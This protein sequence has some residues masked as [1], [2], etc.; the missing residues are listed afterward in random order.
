MANPAPVPPAADSE[1][2]FRGCMSRADNYPESLTS[3]GPNTGSLHAHKLRLDEKAPDV[4][5]HRSTVHVV[6]FDA[7]PNQ[8]AMCRQVRETLPANAQGMVT[9]DDWLVVP[10]PVAPPARPAT[11]T[12]T[13]CRFM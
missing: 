9:V 8:P 13:R 10:P 5:Y 3:I 11:P 2:T 4:F 1:T 6:E 7:D 12:S